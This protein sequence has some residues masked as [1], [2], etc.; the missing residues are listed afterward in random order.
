[1][2]A[3][4]LFS[5]AVAPRPA[6]AI[7]LKIAPRRSL[8]AERSNLPVNDRDCF[9]ASFD[10]ARQTAAISAQDAP[11]N[12]SSCTVP[13]GGFALARRPAWASVL[14][15]SLIC[16]LLI[17]G[18]GRRSATP[19]RDAVAPTAG[20]FTSPVSASPFTSPPSA[21]EAAAHAADLVKEAAELGLGGRIAFHSERAGNFDIWTMKGD[22]SDLRQLTTSAALDVEPAWSPNGKQI[23]FI[24]G[25]DDPRK[26][27]LYVMD[28]DGGNQRML[29]ALDDS[30]CI[31]PAWSPD[32]KQIAFYSNQGGRYGLHL[33]NADGGDLKR[34]LTDDYNNLRPSWS[35]DGKKLVFVSDREGGQNLYTL[36][37]ATG[38]V[39]RLT[40]G[41]YTD[42]APRWSPDGK[43]IL[44][45]SNRAG[46]VRGVFV[47]PAAGGEPRLL[48][49]PPQEDENPAWAGN[50]KFILFSSR[51]TQ[52]WELYLV[53][54]DGKDPRPLTASQGMDR[55]P[56]WTR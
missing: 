38:A 20:A 16:L 50:G 3:E 33:V 49:T 10:F 41:L 22:G 14:F 26:L 24:S 51:R 13:Q 45:V 39:T 8:R 4:G 2:N 17:V 18:C 46:I 19:T 9:V 11:R 47:T 36:T 7:V 15:T 30:L 56:V 27:N 5:S 44:F 21:A 12:D 35:P 53:R 34:L 52:D 1:M 37:P 23:A 29:A 43:T 54:A 28:A 32:G 31:G 55:F 42:D 48:M 6:W 40:R 25:R